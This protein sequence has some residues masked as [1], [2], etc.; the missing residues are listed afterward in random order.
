MRVAAAVLLLGVLA[1]T[2]CGPEGDLIER[3]PAIPEQATDAELG[4]SP[5]RTALAW[6][7]AARA[8][9]TEAL[10]ARLT[11]AARRTIDLATLR[12]ALKANFGR[13]AEASEAHVLYT[14]R[15]AGRATVYMRIDGGV[16]VDDVLVKG[17]AQ[18]LAL[19]FVESNGAWLIEN[20]AWLRGQADSY[21]A[22]RD[23]NRR[24][25][26]EALRKQAQEEAGDK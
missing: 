15:R 17:G 16:L 18:M 24:M 20:G 7:D 26:A 9:D 8:R 2:S 21:I 13:F 11:P 5:A 10:V 25:K 19:P 23:L 3:H 4:G 1:L 6:W 14:E 12:E 22:I